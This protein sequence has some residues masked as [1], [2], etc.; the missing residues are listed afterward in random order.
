MSDEKWHG[1]PGGYTNHGCRCD[2]CRAALRDYQRR[3]RKQRIESPTPDRVHG[4]VNG[5]G[6]YG[7]RC[8]RC[9]GAWTKNEQRRRRIRQ[10]GKEP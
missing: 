6:N 10:V 1:T 9:R 3:R 5:Y 4:T 8:D 7:C 2:D